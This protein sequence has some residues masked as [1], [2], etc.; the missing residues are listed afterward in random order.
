MDFK[1]LSLKNLFFYKVFYTGYWGDFI[2]ILVVINMVFTEEYQTSNK[3]ISDKADASTW[4][5]ERLM[6]ILEYCLISMLVEGNLPSSSQFIQQH[7]PKSQ[8]A[9]KTVKVKWG[10]TG[11]SFYQT[12]STPH[13]SRHMSIKF[14]RRHLL[15]L[16]FPIQ[17][18]VNT[19]FQ[20]AVLL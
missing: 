4:C 9:L 8:L 1:Q 12:K 11:L 15:N 6:K 3:L 17:Y 20:K 2:V 10:D 13:H 14:S 19:V 16:A 7:P 18:S 5:P